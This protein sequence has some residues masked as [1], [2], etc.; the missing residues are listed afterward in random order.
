M[1]Y[2]LREVVGFRLAIDQ[3]AVLLGET[4][5]RS[6]DTP[7]GRLV[8]FPRIRFVDISWILR[9]RRAHAI[10]HVVEHADKKPNMCNLGTRTTT[11]VTTIV[12]IISEEMDL[13]L[14]YS[15]MGGD[16]GWTGDIPKCDF[17]SRTPKPRLGACTVK[18]RGPRSEC[19]RS[20]LG[21]IF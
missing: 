2:R 20:H 1:T 12:E 5:C 17:R 10:T 19:S 9:S 6:M 21:T 15:Y 7:L 3:T 13:D 16:C 8:Q 18:L 4:V 11:S 14:E